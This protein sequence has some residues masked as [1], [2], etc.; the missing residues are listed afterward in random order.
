MADAEPLLLVDHEKPEIAKLDVLRKQPMR[1]DDDVDL[2]GGEVGEDLLLFRFGPEPADHLHAH[3]KS[4]EPLLDGLLVLKRQHR[5]RR[6]KGNLLAVH[7]G[8]EG[9]AQRH[10]CL[11][12]ADVAAQQ[13]I[14]RR[15]RFHVALDVGDS[16]RLIGRQVVLERVLE[17]LLPVGV[18]AERVPGHGLAR[19][20]K[21]EELLR[22]VAHRLLDPALCA[23]P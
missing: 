16:R 14:H 22:H 8:F 23:L 17:F 9:G 5:G 10:F 2:A 11:A 3:G 18:R 4:G 1:A 13:A 21:L 12:I 19:G 15:R 6:E 20:I 7:D